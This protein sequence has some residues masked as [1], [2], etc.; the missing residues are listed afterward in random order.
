[1]NGNATPD[2]ADEFGETD[3]LGERLSDQAYFLA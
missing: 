3:T 1:L 2:D